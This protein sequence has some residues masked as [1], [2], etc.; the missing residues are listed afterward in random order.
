MIGELFCCH[1]VHPFHTCHCTYLAIKREKEAQLSNYFLIV[2]SP[3]QL[4]LLYFPLNNRNVCWDGTIFLHH[5]NQNIKT[6][7][8]Q[9][10]EK[11]SSQMLPCWGQR[12]ARK[13]S[14]HYS[15]LGQIITYHSSRY[16][17]YLTLFFQYS[18]WEYLDCPCRGTEKLQKR[19][20][21]TVCFLD[22]RSQTK[23]KVTFDTCF[24]P[25]FSGSFT[26][27]PQFCSPW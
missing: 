23:C 5:P 7:A 10:V 12:D 6:F 26:W 25:S 22:K 17:R 2:A 18:N 20:Y 27:L 3:T 15:S 1:L 4:T 16:P 11:N 24:R 21:C 14:L 9:A 13:Y 8:F 19:P